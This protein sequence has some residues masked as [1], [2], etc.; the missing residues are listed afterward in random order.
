[1]DAISKTK[2]PAIK[3]IP[4][5]PELKHAIMKEI[6]H[7]VMFRSYCNMYLYFGIDVQSSAVVLNA[8]IRR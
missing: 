3:Y 4:A 7:V 8:I 2:W 1:M 6:I 5:L